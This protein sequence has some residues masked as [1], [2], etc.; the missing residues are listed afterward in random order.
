MKKD[1]LFRAV[2]L[3]CL[4]I[5]P[6]YP[7]IAYALTNS[8]G[9]SYMFTGLI[10][11][12]PIIALISIVRHKWLYC[13]LTSILTI[14][15]LTDLTMV[16]LYQDYLL[17]G[18]I[19]STIKTNPQE[20]SEFYHTNLREVLRWIPLLLIC[21]ASCI[22]YRPS[23]NRRVS[24]F[25]ILAALL[26]VPMF[27][28]Y[29][30]F[31]FYKGQLTLRYYVDNRIWNRPPYNVPFQCINAHTS[32]QRKKQWENMKNINMGATRTAVPEGQKEIYIF[33]IG[34]SLRY[35]NVSLNKKYHRPTTPRLEARENNIMLFDDYYSQAC[36]TMYSVPQLV[37]RATPDNYELNYAE[38]SIIE[39]YR[40]CG[41]KVFTIVSNTNLLSYETYLSDGVDSLIIVP[42]I[43]K[44]GEILSGD[45]TMIHI[46]DSL[47]QEHNKLFIMMQFYGNHSFFTNYEKEFEMYNPNSNNCDAEMVR[48]SMMLINAYDNSILYTDYILSSIIDKID[49]PNT[50]SA[51]MFVSDHGEDICK[52]GAGH[53]GNC[54]PTIKE[55]HV[56]FIFWWSDSYK[57]LYSEKVAN[58]LS[59]KQAKVNGDN[60]YYTLCDLADIQLEE[61]YN[62]PSWSVLSPSFI[63]HERL[64]L[65][66]DGVT[67]IYPDR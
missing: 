46:V 24:A 55:Y 34:E 26:V 54:T 63:E 6:L 65:V 5:I 36:L 35:D 60:I 16:D 28:S 31:G 27:V 11:S 37:T 40:E 45:K 8:S 1:I 58:A 43:V 25:I 38:R 66:P 39:P 13:V 41:F 53:G 50:V 2:S 21:V 32:L 4:A 18:G 3:A 10:F 56:P 33:A 61:Q 67:C 59:R 44:D 62:H 48:D 51:F 49:R 14:L 42:N 64:I 29:K 52:G 12:L 7:N 17:P 23:S 57:E 20:A 9:I 30:L 15:A 47:A 19:I 22:L